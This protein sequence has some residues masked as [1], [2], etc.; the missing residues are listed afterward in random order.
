MSDKKESKDVKDIKD[1]ET[2]K[3]TSSKSSSSLAVEGLSSSKRRESRSDMG[4]SNLRSSLTLP[5]DKREKLAEKGRSAS[6]VVD[7]D[8]KKRSKVH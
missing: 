8:R 1:K 3:R 2:K 7:P 6:A 5:G 4:C